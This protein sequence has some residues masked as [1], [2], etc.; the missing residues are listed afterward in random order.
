MAEW[1]V[2]EPARCENCKWGDDD[3][4][5]QDYGY[6]VD[7]CVSCM[8]QKNGAPTHWEPKEDKTE[9]PKQKEECL[10]TLHVFKPQK[11]DNLELKPCPFCGSEEIYY[12]QYRSAAGERWKVICANCVA[13]IDPGYAQEKHRVQDMWNRRV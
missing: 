13:E 6:E 2:E 5:Y 4:F 12:V 7:P 8:N 11:G 10:H 3:I 1:I 9:P